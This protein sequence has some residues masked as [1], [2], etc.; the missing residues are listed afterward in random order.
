MADVNAPDHKAERP[1][2]HL[3]GFR[4]VL[5]VDGYARYRALIKSGRVQLAACWAN[6]YHRFHETAQGNAPIATKALARVARIYEVESAI[7]GT[8]ADARRTVGQATAA[9]VVEG[10]RNWFDIQLGGVAH[11]SDAA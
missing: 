3:Q 6:V 7:R 10:P 4:G 1:L 2:A 5:Q 8:S 11:K 9:P